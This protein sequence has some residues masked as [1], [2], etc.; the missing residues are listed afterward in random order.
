[1]TSIPAGIMIIN[2]CFLLNI[3]VF[4][5]SLNTGSFSS[6]IQSFIGKFRTKARAKVIII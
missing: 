6:L 5:F 3:I 4:I 2:L 1:M